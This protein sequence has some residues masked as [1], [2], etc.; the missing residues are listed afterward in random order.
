MAKIPNMFRKL[1]NLNFVI[2][3]NFMLRFLGLDISIHTMSFGVIIINYFWDA[4]LIRLLLE[5]LV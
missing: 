4:I 1:E 5:N 3:S 2:V